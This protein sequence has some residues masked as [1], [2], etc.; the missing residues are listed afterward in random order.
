MNHQLRAIGTAAPHRGQTIPVPR[1]VFICT[2]GATF[3]PPYPKRLGSLT[4]RQYRA[5]RRAYARDLRAWRAAEKE[6]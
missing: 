6:N 5:A 4:A 3:V 2:C 1:W